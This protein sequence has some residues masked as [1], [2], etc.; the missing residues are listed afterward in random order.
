MAEIELATCDDWVK[1]I[2]SKLIIALFKF[3][4]KL[5]IIENTHIYIYINFSAKK[6]NVTAWLGTF[7]DTGIVYCH[8]SGTHALTTASDPTKP[9][10]KF[11]P[12]GRRPLP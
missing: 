6:K 3:R 9:S 8:H 10:S 4:N 5:K 2:F 12:T 1:I 11:P 7:V